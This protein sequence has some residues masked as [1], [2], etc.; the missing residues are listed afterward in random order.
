MSKRGAVRTHQVRI[1]PSEDPVYK[2]EFRDFTSEQ[3]D[4]IK[5]LYPKVNKANH[6]II[7]ELYNMRKND[8]EFKKMISY[9]DNLEFHLPQYEN[10]RSNEKQRLETIS[11]ISFTTGGAKCQRPTCG[12]TNTM[13]MERQTRKSDEPATL[14]TK[15]NVCGY[16]G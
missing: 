14:I 10:V 13:T 6:W 11:K 2:L 4:I 9:G 8:S 12:S 1:S 3:M 5:K 15:C 7:E 16:E